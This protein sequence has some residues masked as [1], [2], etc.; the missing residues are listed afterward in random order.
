MS[1]LFRWLYLRCL[2]FVHSNSLTTRAPP[3]WACSNQHNGTSSLKFKSRERTDNPNRIRRSPRRRSNACLCLLQTE[4]ADGSRFRFG[5]CRGSAPARL[6]TFRPPSTT[7]RPLTPPPLLSSHSFETNPRPL[8][9]FGLPGCLVTGPQW[10]GEGGDVSQR[11]KFECGIRR[12][13]TVGRVAFGERGNTPIRPRRSKGP[14][15]K[16]V[17][18]CKKLWGDRKLQE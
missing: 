1:S 4:K 17:W 9:L 3:T 16:A 8:S 14:F 18:L 12:P 11:M 13:Y 5:P 2:C 6:N 7:L 10:R 15:S